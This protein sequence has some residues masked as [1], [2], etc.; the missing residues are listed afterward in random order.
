[1]IIECYF[2]FKKLG[3]NDIY[4][5]YLNTSPC[6]YCQNPWA[7]DLELISPYHNKNK[8]KKNNKNNKKSPPK[9]YQKEVN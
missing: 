1:M 9:I 3:L 4:N 5:T 7:G 8:K 2:A 6:K